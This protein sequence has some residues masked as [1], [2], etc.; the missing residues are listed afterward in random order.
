MLYNAFKH[1]PLHQHALVPFGFRRRVSWW[2]KNT[3]LVLPVCDRDISKRLTAHTVRATFT[4]HGF[5]VLSSLFS[6]LVIKHRRNHAPIA[7]L[8]AENLLP[9]PLYLAFPGSLVGRDSYEY[10]GSSVAMS[11]S[12]GR[13]SRI[14]VKSNVISAFREDRRINYPIQHDQ[15]ALVTQH[16]F[17]LS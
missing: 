17:F 7:G 15:S 10:Y 5:P 8:S 14:P 3:S 13:R 12:A 6:S 9:F 1:A 4:A 11:L 2:L 16:S